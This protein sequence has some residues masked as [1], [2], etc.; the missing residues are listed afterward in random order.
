M[1]HAAPKAQ[2]AFRHSTM[3]W[4]LA[5]VLPCL[6]SCTP[7]SGVFAGGSWQASGLTHQHIRALAVDPNNLQAL[8]AGDAQGKIFVSSDGG[9]HWVERSS[10]LPETNSIHA[11]SFDVAGKNLFAA[12]DAGLYVSTDAARSWTA[13]GKPGTGLPP[14]SFTALA[15]DLNS[16]RAIYVGTAA[17]GVFMSTNGG[18]TW[19]SISN[20]LSSGLTIN[21][22]TFD[23]TNQQLWAATSLGVYRS[24]ERGTTWQAY[25]NG[26]PVHVVVYSIQPDTIVIGG[27]KGLI[28]AGTSHG[29]F[30]SQD[31]GADW[32]ASSESLAGTDVRFIFVD[33]HKPTTLYI[34]TSVGAL[35]SDDS[36]QS[37]SGIAPGLPTDQP[38]YTLTWGAPNYSQLFAAANDVYLFPGTN[39]AFSPARLIAL[40]IIALFFFALYRIATRRSRGNRRTVFKP[41]GEPAGNTEVQ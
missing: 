12:T 1:R 14:N 11:L 26:L 37:W 38:V 13:V 29:F 33:F 34:G 5:V 18:D 3:L 31:A 36:G 25:N 19:S 28:F 2:K 6:S 35:R 41:A 15:F 20:G 23:A 39:S 30:Y 17:H 27:T 24:N 9:Q 16:P 21:A 40:L 10:G 7:T 4:L 32:K 8:Y 22:L